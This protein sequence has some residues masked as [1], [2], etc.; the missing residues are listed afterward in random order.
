ME[1]VKTKEKWFTKKRI[2]YKNA[3]QSKQKQKIYIA[4]PQ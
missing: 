3:K 2:K 1:R 4:T